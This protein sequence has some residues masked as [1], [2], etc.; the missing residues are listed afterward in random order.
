VGL[1]VLLSERL[2]L[3]QGKSIG[4][5]TNHSGLDHDGT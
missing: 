4:L 2:D 5:V 1:D 3:I